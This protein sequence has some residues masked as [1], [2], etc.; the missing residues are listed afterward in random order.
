MD[1]KTGDLVLRYKNEISNLKRIYLRGLLLFPLIPIISGIITSSGFVYTLTLVIGVA[2]L[3]SA[4]FGMYGIQMYF[5]YRRHIKDIESNIGWEERI[6][7][8]R[9]EEYDSDLEISWGNFEYS[10]NY[11]RRVYFNKD[12]YKAFIP[13][14]HIKVTEDK[15]T[16]I[17]FSKV[18]IR[19]FRIDFFKDKVSRKTI[20]EMRKVEESIKPTFDEC[21][22]MLKAEAE[23]IIQKNGLVEPKEEVDGKVISQNKEG[24]LNTIKQLSRQ[25]KELGNITKVNVKELDKLKEDNLELVERATEELRNKVNNQ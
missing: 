9:Y 12:T 13:I 18:S 2:M 14:Q 1:S 25:D 21:I 4:I 23:I 6:D 10:V 7:D 22:V 11:L 8:I 16:I 5:I 17:Q 19:N 20:K 3:Y 15:P 24:M